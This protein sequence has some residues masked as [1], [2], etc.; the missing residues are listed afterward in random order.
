ME[1][2]EPDDEHSFFRSPIHPDDRLWR[3]PSEVAANLFGPPPGSAGQEPDGS[4]LESDGHHESHRD[5]RPNRSN[6][7]VVAVASALGASLLSTGLVLIAGA[8]LVGDNSRTV[9]ER[10]MVP[11]PVAAAASIHDFSGEGIIEVVGKVRPA[12]AQIR[13][14][15]GTDTVASA[16][17]F[18][19][20]GHLLTS[21]QALGGASAIRVLLSDGREFPARLVGLDADTDTAVVKIEGGPFAV[22]TLGSAADLRVGQPAIAFGAPVGQGRG[23]AVSLGVV[24]GL[25]RNVA[26]ASGQPM[27]FDMV[28]TDAPIAAG[29][30][31][32]ALVDATG[33]VV[34]IAAPVGTRDGA[35]AGLGFA[36]PIE[37]AHA[38]AEQIIDTGAAQAV[39]L[40]LDGR[41]LDGSLARDMSLEG[42]AVVGEV[43]A[44][45]PAARSGLL[46]LDVIVAIDGVRFTTMGQMVSMLR[47]HR[48]GDAVAVE[49]RRA[50]QLRSMQVTLVA[51]PSNH[52]S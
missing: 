17:V 24:S 14:G 33:S 6:V 8:L 18:R 48:P 51:R 21:A 2:V 31:G 9:V 36:T 30:S 25:H 10:E 32:G 23:V 3:H 13:V 19:S 22:A 4:G 34:G 45:S 42:G 15:M 27:L 20:D 40:G 47:R 11:R 38:V 49:I 7:W 37:L 12:I 52:Q 35:E 41:D 28:Q 1:F 39:W 50:G 43:A 29:C 46:E 5:R 44:G 16:V 26:A